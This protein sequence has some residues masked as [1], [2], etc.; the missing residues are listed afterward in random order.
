MA[1]ELPNFL[2]VVEASALLRVGRTKAY[3]MAREWRESG[4]RSG[5]P[6]VDFGH[7]LRVPVQALEEL[8][9]TELS[10]PRGVVRVE[11][12]DNA[13][14]VK[15]KSPEQQPAPST[16]RTRRNRQPSSQVSLFEPPRPTS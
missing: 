3:A 9:D 8:I 6:V 13:T 16:P 15:P 11:D 12:V 10:G 4:G 2:T 5:L 1:E 14:G 7:V